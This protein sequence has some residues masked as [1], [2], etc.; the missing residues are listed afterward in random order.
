V[1]QDDEAFNADF[2]AAFA[3]LLELGVPAFGE[4]LLPVFDGVSSLFAG[5]VCS[6]NPRQQLR[7]DVHIT[8]ATV[9]SHRRRARWR[10]PACSPTLARHSAWQLLPVL[11]HV[12]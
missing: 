2:A 5:A 3:K 9:L 1:R 7:M 12:A 4:V 10:L 11:T 6:S 8:H